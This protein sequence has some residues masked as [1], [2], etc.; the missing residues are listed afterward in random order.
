MASFEVN[1]SIVEYVDSLSN[2][3]HALFNEQLYVKSNRNYWKCRH[4]NCNV[5]I[6]IENDIA[7][8]VSQHPMHSEVTKLEKE[9]FGGRSGFLVPRQEFELNEA[10]RLEQELTS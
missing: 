5:L 1:N 3:M 9:T 8:S 6:K 2:S 4:K 10:I 7:S